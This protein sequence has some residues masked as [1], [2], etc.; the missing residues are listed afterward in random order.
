[1]IKGIGQK[2]GSFYVFREYYKVEKTAPKYE[3][4]V[5]LTGEIGSVIMHMNEFVGVY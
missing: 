5:M 2:F 1:M 3:N 4:K